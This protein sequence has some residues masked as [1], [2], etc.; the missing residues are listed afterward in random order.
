MYNNIL[1]P[2]HISWN[3]LKDSIFVFD[4]ITN[5]MYLLKGVSREFWML[6]LHN[7]DFDDIIKTLA[8]NKNIE[9]SVMRN[10]ILQITK[11]LVKNNLLIWS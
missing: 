10:D 5:K 7:N 1:Y 4:E 9:Y 11:R 2:Q 3:S 8:E 6:I